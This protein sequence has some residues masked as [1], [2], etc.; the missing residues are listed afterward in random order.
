MGYEEN[1]SKISVIVPI[2]NSEKYLETCLRSITSQTYRNLEI[3]LVNDGSTD[4]SLAIC[5]A[6]QEIDPRI[7][8]LS[9]SNA[10]VSEARNDGVTESRGYYLLFIDSDDYIDLDYVE[11]LHRKIKEYNADVVISNGIDFD[12][13]GEIPAK[14]RV[15]ENKIL[16]NSEALK[17]LYSEKYFSSV[18][19]GKIFKRDVIGNTTFDKAMK[20]AEDF[21]F[22]D[23]VFAEA[24]TVVVIPER[25]YHYF[26]R[27]GSVTKSGFDAG[28]LDEINFCRE[29]VRKNQR[30][31]LEIYA[32]KRLIRVLVDSLNRF[33]L[34]PQQKKLL[35][36]Y[37]LEF[38]T[39]YLFSSRIK[40][41]HKL[42]YCLTIAISSI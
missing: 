4:D 34:D 13:D 3:I 40:F 33:D 8:I 6:F 38:A 17:E 42:K 9:K 29:I 2:Y 14:N 21:K 24:D 36:N 23:E 39:K 25:K 10:G 19:W 20:I 7:K 28:W 30:S 27:N 1:K 26:V 12:A 11:T 41:K 22:L 18:C 37:S 16:R 5:K 35:R 31:Q 15:H 32:I